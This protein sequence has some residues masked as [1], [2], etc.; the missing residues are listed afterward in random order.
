MHSQTHPLPPAWGLDA[1]DVP[2]LAS[3]VCAELLAVRSAVALDLADMMLL[4]LSPDAARAATAL[5]LALQHCSDL[6]ETVL[7]SCR[8]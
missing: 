1:A 3:H 5:E 8:R 4:G 6:A 2:G 7:Q